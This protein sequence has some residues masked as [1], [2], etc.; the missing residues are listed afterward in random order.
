METNSIP[1]ILR[2]LLISVTW[3]GGIVLAGAGVFIAVI[4]EIE[5]LY[6][7]LVGPLLIIVFHKTINWIFLK[8]EDA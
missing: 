8:D 4:D 3:F 2:R 7:V 1:E 5:G 6:F